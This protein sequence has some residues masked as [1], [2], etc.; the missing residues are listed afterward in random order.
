MASEQADITARLA[1]LARPKAN[2]PDPILAQHIMSALPQIAT[3]RTVT[4]EHLLR[5]QHQGITLARLAQ[6]GALIVDGM[7]ALNDDVAMDIAFEHGVALTQQEQDVLKA[8]KNAWVLQGGNEVHRQDHD[9]AFGS[10]QEADPVQPLFVRI[11]G[12]KAPQATRLIEQMVLK[13]QVHWDT[14]RLEKAA[15]L[16]EVG[17]GSQKLAR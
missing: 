17:K 7:V 15:A 5:L 4:S 11:S 13:G 12:V 9:V 16:L 2:S 8:A 10:A 6:T 3:E 14:G 1:E